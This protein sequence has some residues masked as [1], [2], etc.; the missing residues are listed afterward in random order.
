MRGIHLRTRGVV[1]GLGLLLGLCAGVAWANDAPCPCQATNRRVVSEV[2]CLD[3]SLEQGCSIST[4]WNEC[5]QPVTLV[6]WSIFHCQTEP[7]VV[8]LAPDE[9][10]GFDYADLERPGGGS[11]DGFVEETFHVVMDG[12]EYPLT[13]SADVDCRQRAS[14]ADGACA[15]APGALVAAGLLW[16]VGP[17]LRGRRRG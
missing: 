13:L 16:L 9:W 6:G 5:D 1:T 8:E 12:R 17:L 11:G 15:A 10:K 2:S 7:C 4:V 3:V 14:S